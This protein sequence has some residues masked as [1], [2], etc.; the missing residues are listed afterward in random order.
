VAVGGQHSGL[1]DD[2]RTL[3]CKL[4]D[5]P[6]PRA[7][8]GLITL[9]TDNVIEGEVLSFLPAEGV[10][11]YRSRIPAA[12]KNTPEGLAAMAPQIGGV[13]E[14]LLPDDHLD[15][16]A[17]GCT[18]GA[19]VIGPAGVAAAIHTARPGVAVSNP[20]SAA[21]DGLRALG[22]KRIALL[23]PYPDRTNAVVGDYVAGQGFEILA[24][25]S[26]KQAGGPVIARIPPEDVYEAG[27]AL[28]GTAGVDALFVSCTALRVASVLQRIEDRIGR[29][30]VASNQAL[31][32]D[33]LRR[34]GVGDAVPNAGRLFSL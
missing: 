20:V 33:C 13:A 10:A 18:S 4:D 25:G 24:K 31:A 16:I 11:L 23:T 14:M 27:V 5:G 7:A 9:S 26:F 29:P 30:V 21:L 8:I 34:A 32:W 12:A 6:A 1:C 28:G 2:W 15:V 22:A 17:F 3:N 19:M